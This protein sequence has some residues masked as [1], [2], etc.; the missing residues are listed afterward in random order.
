[1]IPVNFKVWNSGI[2]VL[3]LNF[4]MWIFST[5]IRVDV[6][7]IL[8]SIF[9]VLSCARWNFNIKLG[10]LLAN[11]WYEHVVSLWK[12]NKLFFIVKCKFSRY[13]SLFPGACIHW[14]LFYVQMLDILLDFTAFLVI[15]TSLQNKVDW[16]LQI[17]PDSRLLCSLSSCISSD[18]L[19]Q[20]GSPKYRYW[21]FIF[22]S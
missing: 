1:M 3:A 19:W 7:C 9:T 10:H 21:I 16:K 15:F 13:I 20:N 6:V 11:A 22:P 18:K 12:V 8:C 17:S 5:S 14:K 2:Q 4:L